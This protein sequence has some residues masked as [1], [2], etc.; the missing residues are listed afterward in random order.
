MI[1]SFLAGGIFR[2]A[3]RF[4]PSIFEQFMDILSE[5]LLRK[6]SLEYE[7]IKLE[8]AKIQGNV[9][10]GLAEIK[11]ET[12]VRLA[13]TKASKAQS[14]MQ[15]IDGFNALVRPLTTLFWIIIYPSGGALKKE[16]LI[17]AL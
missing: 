11:C 6:S 13:R 2:F 14:G 9:Q 5:H 12:P 8:I 1:S 10:L 7:N 16:Y 3:L 4:I 17:K 15:W